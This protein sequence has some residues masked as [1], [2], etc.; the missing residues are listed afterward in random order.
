MLIVNA[1]IRIPA[2]ELSF[3]F[4]R[5]SGPGGQ[6]VN[7][8]NTKVLLRWSPARSAALP[9][10]VRRRLMA[11]YARRFNSAGELLI[12]SQRFRTMERNAADCLAKLK[13]IIAEAARVPRTRRPT[14]P[15][16]A[17]VEKRL[18][19]KRRRSQRIQSRRP[20]TEEC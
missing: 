6:N 11:R 15:P 2:Q 13:E 9:E 4:S 20:T 1:Q 5:S 10:E 17:A 3:S 16:H 19:E 8:R 14:R 18:A 12:V 7:K